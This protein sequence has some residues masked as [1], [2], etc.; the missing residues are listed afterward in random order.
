MEEKDIVGIGSKYLLEI[1]SGQSE[2]MHEVATQLGCSQ[3][4]YRVPLPNALAE[5]G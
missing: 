5:A 1:V 4:L 3:W 2:T